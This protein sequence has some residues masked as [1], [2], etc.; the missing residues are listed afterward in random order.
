M[1]SALSNHAQYQS[2]TDVEKNVLIS[3][4]ILKIAAP[5]VIY[6]PVISIVRMLRVFV[7]C[8][9]LLVVEPV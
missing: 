5:A 6:V 7:I 4:S 8:Q 3:K 1:G 9:I 2:Q